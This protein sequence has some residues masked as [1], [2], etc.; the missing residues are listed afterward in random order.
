[1]NAAEYYEGNK[2]HWKWQPK[3]TKQMNHRTYLL[4]EACQESIY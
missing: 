3:K 2:Q 1:M 4:F